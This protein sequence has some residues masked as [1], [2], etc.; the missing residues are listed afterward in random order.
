MKIFFSGI[1]RGGSGCAM[2][3]AILSSRNTFPLLFSV[4][5][6]GG[7]TSRLG[8]LGLLYQTRRASSIC[9]P[10]K[11]SGLVF[12]CLFYGRKAGRD[13][14][15]LLARRHAPPAPSPRARQHYN[16]ASS[17]HASPH[18]PCAP[19]TSFGSQRGSHEIFSTNRLNSPIQSVR[20]VQI[21]V[22]TA[23]KR[24]LGIL[25]QGGSFSRGILTV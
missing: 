8:I 2:Q 18:I 14:F 21:P 5:K 12:F 25:P 15:G 3:A 22:S 10:K 9:L 11:F 16:K 19:S 6:T 4:E 13:F 17:I 24:S 7:L 20:M 23:T 1:E